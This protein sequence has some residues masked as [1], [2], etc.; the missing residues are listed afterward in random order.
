MDLAFTTDDPQ[1]S[2]HDNPGNTGGQ[3]HPERRGAEGESVMYLRPWPTAHPDYQ[4]QNPAISITPHPRF[5]QYIIQRLPLSTRPSL[6][7]GPRTW[8]AYSFLYVLQLEYVSQPL[9]RRPVV[10]FILRGRICI[11][12]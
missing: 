5:G 8:T 3:G 9:R 2:K 1:Q 6:K 4:P 10:R 11:L 7:A 12:D